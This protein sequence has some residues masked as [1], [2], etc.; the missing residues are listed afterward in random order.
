MT[1]P[2]APWKLQGYALQ[3][4][5]LVNIENSRPLIPPELEI[6]S[7]LPGKTLGGVYL[8]TYETGSILEYN[9]L[10]VVA[11]LVSYRG[12]VGAWISHIYVDNLDSVA[13]GR[14]IWGLPKEMATFNWEKDKISVSQGDRELC[15]LKYQ[16]GWLNL[17]TWWQQSFNGD[18]FGKLDSKLLLFTGQ[19]KAQL[20][21][22]SGNLVIPS[23]SPFAC[24]NLGQ[25]LTTLNCQKLELVAGIPKA[26]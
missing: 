18:V 11:A 3:T 9:E 7:P 17:S 13:G 26:V 21:M 5:H 4:L 12:K 16:K 22:V 10:I 20:E 6:V 15:N 8:S 2:P 24:L 1:Y 23:T 25:P 14:E 19:S